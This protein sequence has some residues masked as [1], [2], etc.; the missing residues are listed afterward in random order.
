MVST[1]TENTLLFRPGD[2][3]SLAAA[4]DYAAT[5]QTGYNFY[6][7]RGRL[8]EALSYCQ[9]REDACGLARRFLSL[10]VERGAK[11]ALVGDTHADFMRFF[12]ACQYAG[13]VP[14]PL[15]ATIFLGGHQAYV[16]QLRRLLIDSQAEIAVALPGF[17][18]FMAE[19]GE[20]LELRFLGEPADFIALPA[21]Q[22]QLSP[23]VANDVAYLQYTSG[24]TRY[25]RGVIITQTA[26]MKNLAEIIVHGVRVQAGDR[27]FSWLPFFHDMG[28][29]GGVLAPMASQIS[30]DYLNTRDFAM[31][32]RLWL[33]LMSQN[34]NTISF[35]PP[36]GYE[37]C[38]RRIR[39]PEVEKFDLCHW[40]VA[41]IGAEIIRPDSLRRFA[42][43]LAPAG[44]SDK[45][46]M[47]CYG[48]AECSLAVSFAPL[49]EGF[50][51]DVI[52]ADHF[53]TTQEA[54]PA[55]AFSQGTASNA[56]SFVICGVPLPDYEVEIRGADG[57]VLPE[58]HCGTLFVRGA[59]VMSGYLGNE[60]LTREVLSADGWLNTGDLAYRV[61]QSIVIAGR[62][63]DLI[64]INGR[65]IWPQDMESIA[66]QQ[67]EVRV[68]DAS[69]FS[70][71]GSSGQEKAVLVVQCRELDQSVC[72]D[73]EHRLHGLVQQAL[74]I[75]CLVEL[76]PRNTL[77]RTT[78]G[79]LSRSGARKGYLER[80]AGVKAAISETLFSMPD[81]DGQA[82]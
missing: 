50:A 59:S 5:G 6:D 73:L 39:E 74:G 77:P 9:L 44:F 45:A 62:Q 20:G 56:G 34:K 7:G 26:V 64:I 40:R 49:G 35:S 69:A 1:P 22:Q 54:L 48:M 23:S 41:G 27:S 70:I 72:I 42:S 60:L 33:T 16:E 13:L 14:V 65:N 68:G 80:H 18:T 58:R 57:Q 61:G 19:A 76:V 21:V 66:E 15:P 55:A 79:K 53:M 12:Y 82:I 30:A 2:F 28:L 10:G 4:L 81:L 17:H 63:K 52:D 46:F 11:V 38:A 32:P 31:R 75:D 43:L 36:F 3:S 78:S 37:L 29:V 24:S 8:A 71:P 51:V 47:P 25:P 67:P